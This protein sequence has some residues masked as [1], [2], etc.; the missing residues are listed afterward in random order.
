ES[1]GVMKKKFLKITGI[2]V[3]FMALV[4]FWGYNKYFKPDQEIQQQ[5]NNQFGAGFF[6]SFNDEQVLNNSA[7]NNV[8]SVDD[9]VKTDIT[10]TS[11]NETTA[12]KRITLDEI[13]NQYK[14][15]FSHLQ[16]VAMSRLDTLY[17]S[18]AQEYKQ[19]SKAG[20]LNRS[21]LVQKYI[22]AGTILEANLNSQFYSTL[23]AMQ[24]ELIAN[25][26]PTDL[27][28]VYK[29]EYEKA[30]SYKRSQLLAKV[31]Q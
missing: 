22:Q 31:R 10:P 30:K 6:N 8:K 7:V 19:S 17:S 28:G 24:A 25:N 26:L 2:M 4:S 16:S 23:N 15:Q 1:V 3:L 5:L 14:S 9:L 20:T 11:V 13:N 18:A 27:V 12:G 29:N 21:A